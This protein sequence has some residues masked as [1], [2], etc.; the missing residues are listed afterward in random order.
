[1]SP[2]AA[3]EATIIVN[4]SL[5]LRHDFPCGL[6]ILDP[7]LLIPGSRTSAE[8]PTYDSLYL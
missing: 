7:K 1:M 4:P 3:I 2:I 8:Y 6:V 5:S